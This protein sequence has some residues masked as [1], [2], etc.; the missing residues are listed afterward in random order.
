MKKAS[1]NFR[2]NDLIVDVLEYAFTEWLV[3]QGVFTAFKT[4]YDVVFSPFGGF[5]D[6]LRAHIRH[7]LCNPT[8]GLSSFISCAFLFDSTPEGRNFWCDHSAA[9]KR[10]CS[11]LQARL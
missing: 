2:T 9:W 11:E 10:F 1:K 5:R 4:N 8:L 3:R 6:R 7:S